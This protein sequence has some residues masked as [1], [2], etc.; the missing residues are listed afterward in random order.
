MCTPWSPPNHPVAYGGLA[1]V[2]DQREIALIQPKLAKA[3]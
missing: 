3:P 1:Q 2:Q